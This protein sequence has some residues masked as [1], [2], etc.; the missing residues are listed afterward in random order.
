MANLFP[1][2]NYDLAQEKLDAIYKLAVSVG[3][4]AVLFVTLAIS[5]ISHA[6][7]TV[8]GGGSWIYVSLFSAAMLA[9][10]LLIGGSLIWG[11]QGWVRVFGCSF[12]SLSTYWEL[13]EIT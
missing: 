1:P 2:P 9:I 10:G 12:P 8:R 11:L 4:G 7:L 3:L 6:I 13:H 5:I